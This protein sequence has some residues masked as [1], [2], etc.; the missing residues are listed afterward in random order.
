MFRVLHEGVVRSTK[1]CVILS[2]LCP[3]EEH[4]FW[5]IVL[6]IPNDGPAKQ[7]GF[8]VGQVQSEKMDRGWQE[9]S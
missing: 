4:A 9:V 5:E 3:Q 8:F 1:M 2:G 7:S 6:I